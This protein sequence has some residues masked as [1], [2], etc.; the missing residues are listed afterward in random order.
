MSKRII[1]FLLLICLTLTGCQAPV[2]PASPTAAPT[3]VPTDAP[4]LTRFS[5]YFMGTFDTVITLIGFADSQETFDR[6]LA[7]VE[8]RFTQ[9]HQTFDKYNTYPDVNNLCTLNQQAAQGPVVVDR[10]MMDLL[11]TTLDWQTRHSDSVNIAMGS[12]L[13]LWHNARDTA[14]YLPENAYVPAREELE[15]AAAHTDCSRILLDPE[16]MTVAYTDPLLQLDLGAVAKG[17]AAERVVQE[18]LLPEMPSFILNAG[19]NVRAGV[20]PADGR[21]AWSI[22]IQDPAAPVFSAAESKEVLYFADQSLVTS[23]TY[24]RYFDL[25]GVRYHHLISPVT[26]M[27]ANHCESLTIV[28]ED[29]F[30]ADFLSTACFLLSYEEGRALVDSLDGV[31]ALWIFK[32][33]STQM[34]DGLKPMAKSQGATNSN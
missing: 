8:D 7:K 27:P 14:L 9:L 20:A 25:D 2:A 28:T 18:I 6:V 15:A 29:S 23:G 32:D 31:E 1:L 10:D 24:Q 30:W 22:G 5:G 33:G 34:T 16:A 21:T 11:T 3:P 12:V 4:A 17:Y 26:L 13:A 19:G